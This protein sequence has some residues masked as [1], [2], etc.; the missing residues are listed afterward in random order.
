[1][2]NYFRD[3]DELIERAWCDKT[4]FNDIYA[5][6]NLNENAVKKILRKKLKRK[7]YIIWR[8]RVSK[9]KSNKNFSI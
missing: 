7:A 3:Y 6:D 2:N 4:S 8:K 1:M 9:I 5:T